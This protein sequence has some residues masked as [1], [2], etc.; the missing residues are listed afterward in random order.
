MKFIDFLKG[1]NRKKKNSIAVPNLSLDEDYD[2]FCD[3]CNAHLNKQPGFHAGGC[4]QCKGCGF[5][6][7]CSEKNIIDISPPSQHFDDWDEDP[8]DSDD[9]WI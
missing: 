9:D 1:E 8:D 5:W 7:D 2:W 4:W 6:N 3:Y